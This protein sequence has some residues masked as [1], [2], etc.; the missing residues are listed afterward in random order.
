[1]IEAYT[2][3]QVRAAET[4]YLE[5]GQGPALMRRAAHGLAL[6][7]L[8]R[9][10]DRRGRVAGAR[11][12]VLAGTGNNGGDGLWAGA[13]LARRGAAV[14]AVAVGD[15]LHP[16]GEAALRAAGGR[17]LPAAD[18]APAL[19]RAVEQVLD[20]DLVLDAVLGT[21]ARGGLRG[22]A[23]EIVR[24]VLDRWPAP[25]GR[26]PLVVACDVPSGVSADT[27]A[28]DGPVL[29]ADATVTF[30]ATKA[31]HLLPPGDRLCGE[32][33]TVPLGL[34]D[35]LPAPALRR[36]EHD[37]VAALWPRPGAGS[38][39]YS[40]GVV[41][42]VAGSATYPGAALM[43]TRAA[44]D[45]GAGM[46]RHLGDA[47][48]RRLVCLTSPEVVASEDHPAD[49]HVQAWVVGPGAV[50]DPAQ[51]SRIDA[52]LAGPVP[53]V[54]DAGALGAAARAAA[55]GALGPAKILT[56][57][58]GELVQVLAWLAALG[59][60]DE[61]P[62]RA[63]VEADP[64]RWARTAAEATGA[65]VVL[66]GATTLVAA[67]GGTLLS[68]ADGSPWLATA[69]SGDT[70]AGVMGAVLAGCAE[71]PDAFAAAGEWARGDARFAVAAALAVAVHGY[72][73]R[74]D[75]LGPVPPTALSAA[76]RSVLRLAP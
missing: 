72:A 52:V 20:A 43:C 74:A 29:P 42:V 66:K 27:G 24:A 7:A 22:T 6:V 48:T 28:A 50:G 64:A 34:E 62:D 56:P 23:A 47:G 5:R 1:M 32:V 4:P 73:S 31:G 76:V 40:R 59:A 10:R 13:E 16:E 26:A 21:G 39:K 45:A 33:R 2:G 67:P 12:V 18:G 25:G 36:L 68:Q 3:A 69:G 60:T 46:V 9:L 35:A 57:H 8:E 54:V 63:A 14:L 37:D 49:L 53:A 65:V 38:H 19:R 41:G 17:V 55:D 71:H 30:G 15:R 70:L 75:G 44:V 11:V 61:A 51:E 58:A